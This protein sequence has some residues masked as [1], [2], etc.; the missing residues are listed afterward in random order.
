MP[1]GIRWGF[2]WGE[3]KTKNVACVRSSHKCMIC[4][5]GSISGLCKV[6]DWW[7]EEGI[8]ARWL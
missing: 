5:Y 4:G 1:E 2:F 8:S 7:M 6:M 3:K